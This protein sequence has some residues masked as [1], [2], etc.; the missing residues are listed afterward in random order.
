MQEDNLLAER[1]SDQVQRA[2]RKPLNSPILRMSRE[3]YAFPS[4]LS[5]RV[6]LCGRD[7]S[8]NRRN[9]SA[10]CILRELAEHRGDTDS[11]LFLQEI[12]LPHAVLDDQ[13]AR[14]V[15]HLR[16]V[17]SL[18][19]G[20]G[21]GPQNRQNLRSQAPTSCRPSQTPNPA[22]EPVLR[23]NRMRGHWRFRPCSARANIHGGVRRER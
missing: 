21:L 9:R 7:D 23:R 20:P 11:E 5:I 18:P 14:S 8:T 22:A 12:S 13:R 6:W 17:S 16:V 1:A 15:L 2:F 3:D 10:L 19:G 4:L